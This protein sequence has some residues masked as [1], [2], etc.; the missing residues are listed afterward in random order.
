[1]RAS[2]LVIAGLGIALAGGLIA[3]AV[4]QGWGMMNDDGYGYGMHGYGMHGYGP[5]YGMMG[6][7]GY[8]GPGYGMMN[9]YGPGYGMMNGYGPGYGMHGYGRGWIGRGWGSGS[10]GGWMMDGRGP[11]YSGPSRDLNLSVDDVKK[12]VERMID[13]PR[14][15]LGEVKEKDADT[16]TADVV[17]KDKDALVQKFAFNRHN[18]RYQPEQ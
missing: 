2:K 10:Q 13:N 4:A 12:Y 11:G 3:P 8:G 6:G 18:G 5:G 1:M 14:L 17:T 16:I 15:K 7:Y 9:G